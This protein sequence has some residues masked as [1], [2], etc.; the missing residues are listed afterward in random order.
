MPKHVGRVL[1]DYIYFLSK[2]C[3]V[4]AKKKKT[5]GRI[6]AP[7]HGGVMHCEVADIRTFSPKVTPV[8]KTG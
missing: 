6:P 4:L 2:D 3:S 7:S 1:Y 5:L 8:V